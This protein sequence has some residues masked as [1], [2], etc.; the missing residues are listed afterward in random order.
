MYRHGKSTDFFCCAYIKMFLPASFAQA[1]PELD[2]E[3]SEAMA[4][5]AAKRARTEAP[6]SYKKVDVTEL[7]LKVIEG[8]DKENPL[9]VVIDGN[10]QEVQFVLTPEGPNAILRGFDM[11]GDKEKRSFNSKEADAK[12]NYLSLYMTLDDQQAK[13]LDEVSEKLKAN[14]NLESVEW[15]P[16]LPK[17][18]RYESSAVAIKVC[19]A[20]DEA[21]LTPLK[22]KQA[23]VMRAGKGWE[24]LKERVQDQ[25][26]RQTAFTG[27]EVMA[28]VKLRPRRYTA[29]GV[30]KATVDLVA[31]QVAIKALEHKFVDVLP[32]W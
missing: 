2:Q 9:Y 29:N 20:G 25:K 5:P 1:P 11:T 4:S 8:K 6:E 22:I 10:R 15:L 24:F 17:S 23:D 19:L 21:N 28:V 30:A 27:A 16:I 3:H 13:F 18:V 7:A 31:T 32:D 14:M 26:Y 12:G